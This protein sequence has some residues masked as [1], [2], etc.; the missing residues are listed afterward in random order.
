M[1]RSVRL[2]APA[3]APPAAMSL[4]LPRADAMIVGIVRASVMRPAADVFSLAAV[5]YE[6][7]TGEMAFPGRSLPEAAHAVL[8]V[9]PVRVL[10]QDAPGFVRAF[11]EMSGSVRF[12]NQGNEE[13]PTRPT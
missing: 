4:R 8:P 13:E 11:V 3:V 5:F 7:T 12:K 1:S 6:M 9:E 2:T 10:R